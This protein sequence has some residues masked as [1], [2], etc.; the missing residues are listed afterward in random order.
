MKRMMSGMA[1]GIAPAM[2]SDLLIDKYLKSHRICL[3][4]GQ[5][6]STRGGEGLFHFE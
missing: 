1:A 6:C 5:D 4:L 2:D 3:K